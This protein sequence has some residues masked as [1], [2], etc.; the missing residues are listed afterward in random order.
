MMYE[1]SF[2]SPKDLSVYRQDIE[3]CGGQVKATAYAEKARVCRIIVS[4]NNVRKFN[5][6]FEA[7]ATAKQVLR[8]I[9][10][11]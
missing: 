6:L 1:L 11:V 10:A 7:T 8:V 5:T 3:N 4:V 9:P 2:G